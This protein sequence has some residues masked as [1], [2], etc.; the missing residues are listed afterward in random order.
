MPTSPPRSRA[1]LGWRGPFRHRNYRLFFGGQLISL[2]GTWM[3]SVAVTW[4]VYRT[5]GSALLLGVLGFAS[6]MP[7]FLISPFAGVLADRLNRHRILVATQ[8]V[9]MVQALVLAVLTLTGTIEAWS[10]V[11]L[12]ILLGV[13]N[14]FDIPVRQSFVHEMIE[15]REDLPNAIALNS[16][17]FNAARLV[18]P[19]IAGIVLAAIGEGMC[20]LVNA[21]SFVAVIAALLAMRLPPPRTA[22]ATGSVIQG[23][24][25]GLRYAVEFA[26][27][28]NL[29]LLVAIVSGL[30]LPVFVLMPVYAKDVLGGGPGTL[31]LLMSAI[32]LGAMSGAITLAS[33]TSI[34]GLVR[35]ATIAT[36]VFASSIIAFAYS[37]II[38]VS[39]PLLF[40][41]GYGMMVQM[42]SCNTILQTITDD[43]KRGRVMSFYTMAFMGMMPL[44]SLLAGAAA[45]R[46]GTPHTVM[47]SGV[48]CAAGAVWFTTRVRG[49]RETI[50]PVY[51]R[52]G[53]IPEVSAALEATSELSG[54][55]N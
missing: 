19:S 6:Q 54:P 14:G 31:G 48:V 49:L 28:K 5:T 20:F 1:A 25:D 10:I 17:M 11:A 22:P 37:T 32:G 52:K 15:N 34:V 36:A 42:A 33:R 3:Q 4:L 9:A 35:W 16:S 13:I 27:I 38:W 29:L 41:V 23:L 24:R 51:V 30:G 18:G 47:A 46:I 53:I 8:A 2:V 55:E 45:S 43:D 50:R 39:L 21:V 40:L 12:S 7:T 44:G 26:P